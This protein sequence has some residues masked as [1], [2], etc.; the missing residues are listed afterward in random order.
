MIHDDISQMKDKQHTAIVIAITL[1]WPPSGR[2]MSYIAPC[3]DEQ[4]QQHAR[5]ENNEQLKSQQQTTECTVI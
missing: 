3:D 5:S 1:S 2:S 4:Q